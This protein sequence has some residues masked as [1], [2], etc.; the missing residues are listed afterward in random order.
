VNA[1][2]G[3]YFEDVAAHQAKKPSPVC[4]YIQ[5]CCE[6]E[7]TINF[8]EMYYCTMR[9][10]LGSTGS[11]IAFIPF[12]LFLLFIFM[13]CL[14][15]TADDYLSPALEYIVL[16]FKISES[17][18]G[19]TFL[20]FGNGAPD[21]FSSIS[22]AMS[23]GTADSSSTDLKV[24]DNIQSVAPLLGSMTFLTT[25]VIALVNYVSPNR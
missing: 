1:E 19:V 4:T 25:V 8:F 16:R 15:S 11:L 10:S 6:P 2:N 7:S 23:G 20:A 13:Y 9:G 12:G 14:A 3:L 22:S 21:V 18:A 24:G 5:N 17:L